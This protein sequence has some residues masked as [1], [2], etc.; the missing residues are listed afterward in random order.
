MPT[1]QRLSR[2]YRDLRRARRT[3]MGCQETQ[4]ATG[5]PP[6]GG[7]RRP[8][9]R[10]HRRRHHRV[11]ARQRPAR[12]AVPGSAKQTVTVNVTYLVGSRHENYGETGMAHLLEHLV[13]KGSTRHTRHSQR[14]GGR[15]ARVPTAPPR[16]TAPTTSRPSP[17]PTRTCAGRST[18]KP[19]A[20]STRS[21]RKKDLD[22]EMT[23]VRNEFEMRRERARQRAV[24]AHA[25][26]RLRLAQLRQVDD[27][28]ALRHRER[29]D[30][31]AAGLLPDVLPAGQRHAARRRQ[32]RRSRH[33]RAGAT[34]TSARSRGP[35]AC[36]P[37]CTPSSRAGRRA[38]R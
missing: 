21:S 32:V 6:R 28:R 12:A 35:R 27:R 18:S 7:S 38:R 23:V 3:C 29:A 15:T 25:V 4:D 9:T 37:S 30:R 22:S 2:L 17:P 8:R 20:W 33:A 13:F 34:S 36:C 26:R 10:H 24:R 5:A 19:T 31:A 1:N 14:A 16:G 11:P